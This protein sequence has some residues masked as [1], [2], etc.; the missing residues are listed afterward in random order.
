MIDAFIHSSGLA[1]FSLSTKGV[2]SRCLCP[3]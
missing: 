2:T 3:T 1:G